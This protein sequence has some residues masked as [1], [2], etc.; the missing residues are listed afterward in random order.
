MSVICAM[1]VGLIVSVEELIRDKKLFI[2]ER[3]LNLSMRSYYSSKVA[4]LLLIS[5]IQTTSYVVVAQFVLKL[6][7]NIL[8][9]WLSLLILSV[10][11]NL[12]GLIISG[13]L[14]SQVA[15]YILIP[16]ILVPQILLSG[17]VVPYDKIYPAFSSKEYV[18]LIG[19]LMP[20]RWAYESLVVNQFS[21]NNYQKELIEIEKEESVVAYTVFVQ[22]PQLINILEEIDVNNQYQKNDREIELLRNEL[23]RLARYSKFN[24]IN[25]VEPDAFNN[26]LKEEIRVYLLKLKVALNK[27]Y[28]KIVDR[29]DAYIIRQQIGFGDIKRYNEFRNRNYNTSVAELVLNTRQLSDI[30]KGRDKLIQ[31]TDP[32]YNIPDNKYGRSH[33]YSPVKRVGSLVVNTIIFNN[34]VIGVMSLMLLIILFNH[35]KPGIVI[36]KIK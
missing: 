2:R 6:S 29:K 11:A 30:R 5:I 26:E 33:F 13:V 20:T 36:K 32:I 25:D 18:P 34:L 23:Y 12:L 31:L 35:Y 3:F 14:D 8:I 1:F 4:F 16:L 28:N 21:N 9:F 7:G 24:R 15:I 17:V 22:I 19:D 27:R 10:F